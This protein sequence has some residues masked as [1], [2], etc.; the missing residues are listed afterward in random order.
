MFD[1][2][3]RNSFNLFDS[4]RFDG[5]FS[6]NFESTSQTATIANNELIEFENEGFQTLKLNTGRLLRGWLQYL[7]ELMLSDEV[8]WVRDGKLVKV[9]KTG[10]SLSLEDTAKRDDVGSFEFRLAKTENFS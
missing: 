7:K 4:V 5:S 1:L 10:K 2:I 3:F 9:I 6:Q 8:Y